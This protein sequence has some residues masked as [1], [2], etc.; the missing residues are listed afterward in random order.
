MNFDTTDLID[1]CMGRCNQTRVRVDLA[2]NVSMPSPTVA[3]GALG[4]G[5]TCTV[6]QCQL[7]LQTAGKTL[8]DH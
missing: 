2:V 8:R 5:C 7:A 4:S 1:A 6:L 3:F